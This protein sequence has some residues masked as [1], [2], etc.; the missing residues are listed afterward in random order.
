M[1]TTPS[2][3]NTRYLV[4]LVAVAGIALV[5]FAFWWFGPWSAPLRY[6]RTDLITLRRHVDSNPTDFAA[7]KELGIRLARDGDS[8]AEKPLREAFALKPSDP[9]VATGLGELLLSEKR[10]PESFQVLKAA[11]EH[12]PRFPLARMALGRLYVRQASYHHATRQFEEVTKLD[13]GFTEA[14]HEVAICYLQM[15]QSK[16][17]REAIT[18]ALRQSPRQPHFLALKGSVDVVVGDID[19]GIEAA[20]EAAR[21]APRNLKIQV[22]LA[23]ILVAHQRG[24]D[25]LDRAEKAIA[26]IEALSPEYP[27]L[28]FLKGE[29]ERL[30]GNWKQAARHLE[31]ALVTAHGQSEVLFSLSQ[32]YG[33]L[34][35]DVEAARVLARFRKQQDIQ[36]RIDEVRIA[37]AVDQDKQEL[38]IK[39]ADLLVESGDVE[40]AKSTLESAA[41]AHPDS[42]EVR[43]RLERIH[44]RPAGIP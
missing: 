23:N 16:K 10:Y 44:A 34:G 38:H 24:A 29:V 31:Q 12:N 11:V 42:L 3:G 25:D 26:G 7:W 32:V 1:D 27:L 17:A 39:L 22:N 2:G 8:L 21:L 40:A 6:R 14:W 37:L 28:P 20:R 18:E 43:R 13:P 5:A 41:R 36:R 33:R 19:S 15:Q 35:R 9:E 30:R 4:L